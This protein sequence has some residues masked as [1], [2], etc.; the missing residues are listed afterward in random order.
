MPALGDIMY[1]V[2]RHVC[3]TVNNFSDALIVRDGRVERIESVTARGREVP[4][5]VVSSGRRT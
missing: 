3:P 1:L 2:P 4:M 5:V